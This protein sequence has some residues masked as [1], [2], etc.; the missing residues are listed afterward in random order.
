VPYAVIGLALLLVVAAIA[1]IPNLGRSFLPS[2]HEGNIVIA[3]TQPPGTSLQEN[4][5]TGE[6][7]QR[8]LRERHPEIATVTHRAGRSRLDE[9][10]MPVNFSEFDIRLKEG[11]ENSPE[12][13][14]ALRQT[15]ADFPGLTVNVGQFIEHRMYELLSGVQSQV[16]VDFYGPDLKK[17]ENLAAKARDRLEKVD[18]V[19]DLR[20][21]QLLQ[22][23]GLRVRVDRE[24]A[25]RYGLQPG[26]VTRIVEA[27]LNGLRVSKVFEGSR[28]FDLLVRFRESERD[29]LKDIRRIPL[30]TVD[31]GTVSLG[32]V[33]RLEVVKEPFFIR[34]QD[35]LRRA[36]VSWNVQERDLNSVVQDARARLA[37]MAMPAGYSVEVG[38]EYEGQQRSAQRLAWAGGIAILLIFVMLLQAVRNVRLAGLVLLNLPLAL[39]GGVVILVWTGTTLNVS[40]LVG[41]VALFGIATRNGLLLIARYQGLMEE[42]FTDP[43]ELTRMGARE[44]MAPILMTAA[45][46]ALAVLPLV[47]GSPVGKE[48]EQ[49]L[50][51]VLIGGLVTSTLLNLVVVP[52][53][54]YLLARRNLDR[55][56]PRGQAVES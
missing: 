56:H 5:R 35:G 7:I 9:D 37:G 55:L 28:S 33:A 21:S 17:L 27:S 40:S 48:M 26:E 12:L 10:A 25:S 49:P 42:G 1:L 54:F 23:P 3:A 4:L 11:V 41:S 19:V 46:T 52:T 53:W 30:E 51:W 13:M 15:M 29:S 44:R 18:G 8:V 43:A 36:T 6:A 31:G 47:L 45:T 16:V 24:A 14:G 38:G 32:Q 20:T 22:V 2:F 50:A 39:I 34:H